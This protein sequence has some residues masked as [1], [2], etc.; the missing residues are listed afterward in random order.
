M[1]IVEQMKSEQYDIN[2]ATKEIQRHMDFK[3][4]KEMFTKFL[5]ATNKLQMDVKHIQ[6]DDRIRQSENN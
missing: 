2:V 6:G 3:V 1:T 4:D 5:T